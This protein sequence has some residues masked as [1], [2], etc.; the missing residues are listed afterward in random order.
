MAVASRGVA[1]DMD[2]GTDGVGADSRRARR[3]RGGAG[4]NLAS[5]TQVSGHYFL[6]RRLGFALLRRS[7][8]MEIDPVRLQRVLLMVSGGIATVLLVGALAAGWFKPAGLIDDSTNIVAERKSSALYAVVDGRL[9]PALN[10]VSARLIAGSADLPTYVNA[11]EI[12]KW[13]KGPTVGIEGAPVDTPRV[14]APELSRWAVCDTASATKAGRPMVTGID[15]RLT[16]GDG[17]DRLGDDEALLMSYGDT[18]FLV[19]GGVR[20]PVDISDRVITEGLGIEA[21]AVPVRMSQALY[22]AI[23]VGPALVVPAVPEAGSPASGQWAPGVVVGSVVSSRD[24]ASGEDRFYVVATD[25]VQPV[26]RVVAAMLRQRDS[27]GLNTVPQVSPDRLAAVPRVHV[28]DVDDYP[29]SRVRVVDA[30]V[31]PVTCLAWEWKVHDRQASHY[32]VRGRSLPVTAA[33]R[34]KIVS[35]VGGG[36]GGVQADEVLVGSGASTFVTTTGA[37]PDSSRRET[38]WLVTD[39]GSRYGVPFDKEALK[40]LGLVLDDVRPAPWPM[41]QVWPAGPELSRAAALTVHDGTTVAGSARPLQKQ[42][43]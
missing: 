35:L 31:H 20:M 2:S 3:G 19:H 30:G 9:Y 16:L 15:G 26:S 40:A 27:F 28:L 43:G 17:A 29:T 1:R 32:V 7:V 34:G 5:R 22:D 4:L 23:P 12:A 11:D 37:A 18:V 39:S 24:E 8:R 41:L 36:R 33:E 21:G 25:G 13:P 38:L 42:G 14:V 10:L 6:R